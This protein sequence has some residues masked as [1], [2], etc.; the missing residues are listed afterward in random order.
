MDLTAD[1]TSRE[2]AEPP[3]NGRHAIIGVDVDVGVACLH[4]RDERAERLPGQRAYQVRRRDRAIGQYTLRPASAR[5]CRVIQERYNRSIRTLW[6]EMDMR[7]DDVLDIGDYELV[8]QFDAIWA[9]LEDGLTLG[10]AG[11]YWNFPIA[12]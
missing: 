10:Q 4:R 5:R 9:K 3:I 8:K 2:F 11:C 12:R 7:G 1:L 6:H